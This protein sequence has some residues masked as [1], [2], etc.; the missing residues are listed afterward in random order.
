MFALAY[1]NNNRPDRWLP[2]ASM[3]ILG[4]FVLSRDYRSL[5]KSLRKL[6]GLDDEDD[7]E[8]KNDEYVGR[9]S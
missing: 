2:F 3:P 8:E 5:S 9:S 1:A 7:E 6:L 4:G